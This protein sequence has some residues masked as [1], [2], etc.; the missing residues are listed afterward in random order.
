[1]RTNAY[2]LII[3]LFFFTSVLSPPASAVILPSYDLD[4]LC[5]M[6]TDVIHGTIGKT[7]SVS[8]VAYR[9]ITVSETFKGRFKKG[10][11]I[12][13][14]NLYRYKKPADDGAFWGGE[15]EGGDEVFL[16]LAPADKQFWN[17]F[18]NGL[19]VF[20]AV[21]SGVKWIQAGKVCDFRQFDNPGP[22]VAVTGKFLNLPNPAGMAGF[23][24]ALNASLQSEPSVRNILGPFAAAEADGKSRMLN[25]VKERHERRKQKNE[26]WLFDAIS[27]EALRR[28]AQLND[29]PTLIRALEFASPRKSHW[30]V[31][32]ALK[33]DAGQKCLIEAIRDTNRPIH[34][35][36]AAA[37]RYVES[38]DVL[39]FLQREGAKQ[40]DKKT[41]FDVSKNSPPM[42]LAI[43]AE[44]VREDHEVCLAL[45][46]GLD[47]AK[48]PL[49][50][51][52][53]AFRRDRWREVIPNL[54]RIRSS[55]TST[56]VTLLVDKL[57][58]STR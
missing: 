30:P 25:L 54:E 38:L 5:F 35:R 4:S 14:A 37:R 15:L 52:L 51:Q 56:N 12:S 33:S 13:V 53:Q 32:Q 47:S 57:I 36:S 2:R 41:N 28:L 18:P 11:S 3:A 17:P 39:F 50:P 43:Q 40:G 34:E 42:W 9:E 6:A 20:E 10:E 22:Y 31:S 7:G 44:A 58:Q 29:L 21:D 24:D 1:M 46:R 26:P 55:T 19:E 16:F 48:W 23:R 8:L 49:Y 27:D 45:L